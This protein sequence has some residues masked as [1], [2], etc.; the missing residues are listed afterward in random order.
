MWQNVH[1]LLNSRFVI[2]DVSKNHQ[3]HQKCVQISCDKPFTFCWTAL[4]HYKCDQ[5]S[6]D[7]MSTFRWTVW[8]EG[9]VMWHVTN[10]PPRSCVGWQ[11]PGWIVRCQNITGAN[12]HS[13]RFVGWM[14]NVGRIVAWMVCGWTDRQGT[15][16]L[17]LDPCGNLQ[18][19][20]L[21][22]LRIRWT[23][24]SPC[25]LAGGR[26]CGDGADGVGGLRPAAPWPINDHE[27]LRGLAAAAVLAVGS[28]GMREISYS[29]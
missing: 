11:I 10:R 22:E 3:R 1:I 28:S 23:R 26:V 24:F 12:C 4:G 6:C 18:L 7:K 21:P 8:W 20:R 27:G 14:D 5:K 15:I 16:A 19:S 13:R 2:T 17:V 9:D 29:V 25:R